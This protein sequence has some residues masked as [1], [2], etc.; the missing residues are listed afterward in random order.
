MRIGRGGKAFTMYKLRT[1]VADADTLKKKLQKKNER[2]DGPLFKIKDDPRITPLGRFLRRWDI[3]ELPQLVNV[4]MGNMSIIGPRPHLPE[5][6]KKYKKYQRRVL[7]IKPG[8]TGMAQ[9]HGRHKNSFDHEVQLDVFYIE[10]WSF[11]LD[12]KVLVKTVH[13]V[14]F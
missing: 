6:V 2:K 8:I 12:L 10:N 9:V 7:T 13:I 1:M 3:D 14:L 5:E 4:F 11:L